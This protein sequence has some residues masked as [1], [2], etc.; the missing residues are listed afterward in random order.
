MTSALNGAADGLASNANLTVHVVVPAVPSGFVFIRLD[1]PGQN[2][3]QITSV[4]RSDGKV[5]RL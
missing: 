4:T 5:I 1:D 2:I 3:Y